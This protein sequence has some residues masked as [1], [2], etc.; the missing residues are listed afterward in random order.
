MS[1]IAGLVSLGRH[2]CL[3]TLWVLLTLILVQYILDHRIPI[4]IALYVCIVVS[5]LY[6]VVL[7]V[8][9]QP[10]NL[11]WSTHF[12][13]LR[14]PIREEFL[15]GSNSRVLERHGVVTLYPDTIQLVWK[16]YVD[17]LVQGI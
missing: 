15:S 17:N 6:L 2:L 1:T 10:P 8:A 7:A 4:S 11:F 14:R 13:C 12:R 9:R 16:E 3:P 5:A